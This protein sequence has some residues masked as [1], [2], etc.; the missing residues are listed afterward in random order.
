MPGVVLT[1]AFGNESFNSLAYEFTSLVAKEPF[2]LL[3]DE[4]DTA[5]TV[6]NGHAIGRGLQKS[7]KIHF[8]SSHGFLVVLA[9]HGRGNDIGDRAHKVDVIRTEVAGSRTVGAQHSKGPLVSEDVDGDAAADI[10]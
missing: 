3:I 1:I 5:L 8:A 6:N 4:G 2:T 9:L 10:M 7:A